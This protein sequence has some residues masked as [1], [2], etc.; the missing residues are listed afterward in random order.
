MTC[1]DLISNNGLRI[2][3]AGYCR[4]VKI[5]IIRTVSGGTGLPLVQAR[6]AHSQVNYPCLSAGQLVPPICQTAAGST[7]AIVIFRKSINMGTAIARRIG[8]LIAHTLGRSVT[9][10]IAL[11]LG[12]IQ[13]VG[14]VGAVGLSGFHNHRLLG[15]AADTVS[16]RMTCV[17]EQ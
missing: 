17:H 14:V 8:I 11:H 13:A 9:Q 3:I 1:G 10:A 7:G 16:H 12:H 6:A 4:I 5:R 15:C 2:R